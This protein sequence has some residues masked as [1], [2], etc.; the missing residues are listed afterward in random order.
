MIFSQPDIRDNFGTNKK[1]RWNVTG[2]ALWE[3]IQFSVELPPN[4]YG[5][6]IYIPNV[7]KTI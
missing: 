5:Y 7:A 1:S 4:L 3:I 2:R 6:A